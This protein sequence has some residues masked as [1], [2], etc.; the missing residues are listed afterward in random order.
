MR[1]AATPRGSG[2]EWLVRQKGKETQTVFYCTN[3]K[4]KLIQGY[5]NF[6]F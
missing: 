3:Y 1:N 6:V 2:A 4:H 5:F